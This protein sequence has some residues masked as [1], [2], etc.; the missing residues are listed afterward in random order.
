MKIEILIHIIIASLL[1]S[2]VR[3]FNGMKN[4]C[5][6]AK[7]NNYPTPLLDKYIK[8]LHYIETPLWYSQFG[9]LFFT[10]FAIFRAINYNTDFVSIIIQIIATL[11]IVICSSD[12]ASY[13][14]QGYINHGSN[15]PF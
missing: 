7:G 12:I 9:S 15:L 4:G 10:I 5:F 14:F 11:L 3:I 13:W 1:S 6:Y 8:N 2:I